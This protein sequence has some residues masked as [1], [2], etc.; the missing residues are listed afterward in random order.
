MGNQNEGRGIT[1]CFCKT[2]IFFPHHLVTWIFHLNMHSKL[3]FTINTRNS[4]TI[5]KN[6]QFQFSLPKTNLQV[7]FLFLKT[8]KTKIIDVV[9]NK[10][11]LRSK[12]EIKT[13]QN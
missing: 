5:Q 11:S 10:H 1:S 7:S 3:K 12:Y 13:K 8:L 2:V 6:C 9:A 4:A